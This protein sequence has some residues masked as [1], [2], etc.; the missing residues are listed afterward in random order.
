MNRKILITEDHQLY[1]D[2]MRLLIES[3]FEGSQILEAGDY[4]AA[5]AHLNAHADLY[6]LLL[7]IKIPGTQ[8]LEGLKEIRKKFPTLTIIVVSTLDFCESIDQILLNGA[9][10]FIT[11]TASK[12]EM[13]NAIHAV[14]AG[15][16][17]VVSDN[18]LEKKIDLSKRQIETLG[19]LIKGKSNKEIA[20][21]MG[22]SHAT[23]REHVSNILELLKAEN[24]THAALIA[25]KHGFF[26]DTWY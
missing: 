2:G 10:G 21:E 7:D 19:F 6:F 15:E 12:E 20:A 9:N 16:I 22:V 3:T 17:V 14:L 26:F 13:L 23:V 18:D 1:R 5:L 4:P 8:G 11:K 24:R 25:K